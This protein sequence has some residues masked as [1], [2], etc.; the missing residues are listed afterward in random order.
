MR[1]LLSISISLFLVALLSGCDQR[2]DNTSSGSGGQ[3]VQTAPG[4]RPYYVQRITGAP[5]NT[6]EHLELSR[7][8]VHG[9][10]ERVIDLCE[11]GLLRADDIDKKVR[12]LE[13]LYN[14]STLLRSARYEKSDHRHLW[15][16][17]ASM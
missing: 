8:I 3:S 7:S 15:F 11:A 13:Q 14:C 12:L 16:E 4:E 1:K 5:S 6:V 9:Q 2:F 10:A 17:V